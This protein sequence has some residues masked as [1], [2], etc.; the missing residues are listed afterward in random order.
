MS[1][2]LKTLSSILFDETPQFDFV[3]KAFTSRRFGIP[4]Y[5]GA[6]LNSE[7]SH[8]ALRA[9]ED[10]DL[11]ARKFLAELI[12]SAL[13]L[14]KSEKIVVVPIPSR[15]SAN[16]VRGI[17]H[18]EELVKVIEKDYPILT[19]DILR[20]RKKIA[21][22]SDLTQS[23]RLANMEGAFE[24]KVIPK[25]NIA[26]VYLLDDLVTTGATILAASQALKVRNIQVLGVVTACASARFSE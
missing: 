15:Q 14:L 25:L 3:T 12:I 23:E 18:L 20:H 21:D 22:Q 11:L 8:L 13:N 5:A 2:F 9:K 7:L 10:N 4:V 6:R 26:A 16:R 24:V 19:L 1:K 17:K